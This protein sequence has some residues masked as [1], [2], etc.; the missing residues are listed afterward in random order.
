V[1]CRQ[2]KIINDLCIYVMINCFNYFKCNLTYEE[3][4]EHGGGEPLEDRPNEG[5]QPMQLPGGE[6]DAARQALRSQ[7]HPLQTIN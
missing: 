4:V 2:N 6:S 1:L 3:S 5:E 7:H